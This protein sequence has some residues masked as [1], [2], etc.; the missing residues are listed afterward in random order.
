MRAGLSMRGLPY[1]LLVDAG[2]SPEG[3]PRAELLQTSGFVL[4][5]E[6]LM[7]EHDVRPRGVI[8]LGANT[9]QEALQ[10]MMLGFEKVLFVEGHPGTFAE[11]AR[12]VEHFNLLDAE[13]SA[14]LKVN[15]RTRFHAVGAAVGDRNSEATFYVTGSSLF[16]STL[17]PK[18]FSQ[19]FNY[20]EK[21]EPPEAAAEFLQWGE[22]AV[23]LVEEVRVPM[24][25]LDSMLAEDLQEGWTAEDFNVL[26]M[27]IQ[28][29]EMDALRGARRA[30]K[31]IEFI[32]LEKNYVE[33]YEGNPTPEEL[34]AFLIGEG[35]SEILAMRAGPVGTSAY[36]RVA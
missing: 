18:D 11:L 13:L 5:L 16:C 21:R 32:Q 30:I 25:T 35:F 20:V 8:H 19:W 15:R 17:K 1:D 14:Y 2:V 9:G 4:F 27:N 33:H 29:A 7:G 26:S 36:A 31:Q 6:R 28:G 3:L 22:Q 34:D 12:N 23:K 10:Y 24:R